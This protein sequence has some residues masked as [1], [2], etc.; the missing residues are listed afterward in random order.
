MAPAA[1]PLPV[2]FPCWCR[3]TYSWGGET[4]RDLGFIEGDLIECLN[5][6]DGSWWMG[7]LKR[8]RR[9][10]GLFPSNFV[11]VLDESFQPYRNASPHLLQNGGSISKANSPNPA[12]AKPTPQ[13]SKSM[14]RKPFTAYAAASSP[15]PG[16]AARE[17]QQKAGGVSPNP[18]GSISKHKPYSSMKRS[19]L[20]SRESSP[21]QKSATGSKL[22]NVS[23]A[24][25]VRQPVPRAV[26]PAPPRPHQSYSRAVSP[27]VPARYVA[28]SRAPS[29][30]PP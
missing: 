8:D 19:S 27:A 22:R 28:Q 14:F 10:V 24:P 5:A 13:K 17:V 7:R 9:M 12:S 2:R 30:G 18:N 20:E 1:Q 21:L 25:N 3:A 23:P 15:N 11:E 6:G 4:K 26:S 29:P 16:A